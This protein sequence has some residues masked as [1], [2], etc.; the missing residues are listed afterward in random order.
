MIGH[1]TQE[2]AKAEAQRI[3]G[4]NAHVRIVNGLDKVIAL[5][6]EHGF[7]PI[8]LNKD[9]KTALPASTWEA[10]FGRVLVRLSRGECPVCD[11][12]VNVFAGL[13]RGA[14]AEDLRRGRTGEGP[15]IGVPEK[16]NAP[17]GFVCACGGPSR[18]DVQ[19]KRVHQSAGCLKCNP[20]GMDVAPRKH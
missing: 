4:V 3:Y 17:C 9:A 1:M 18:R 5:R 10:A 20:R 6:D 16:H 11:T 14:T 12:I 15:Q 7:V 2:E 8:P 19:K 13:Q